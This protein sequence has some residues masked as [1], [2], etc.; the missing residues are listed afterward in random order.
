MLEKL[1]FL[2]RMAF[3]DDYGVCLVTYVTSRFVTITPCNLTI[4]TVAAIK[5][6]RSAQKTVK[7]QKKR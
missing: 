5:P 4:C 7:K 3:L 6:D 1:P 2:R